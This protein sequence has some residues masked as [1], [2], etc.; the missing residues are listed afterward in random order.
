MAKVEIDSII[1]EDHNVGE[2]YC[3]W[4]QFKIS[5]EEILNGVRFAL[6]DCPHALVWT[7]TYHQDR[8]MLIIH[9]TID[10]REE[11]EEFIESIQEFVSD[12]KIGLGDALP[13][14]L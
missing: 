12:W 14:S 3:L 1:S 7:I 8:S 4:G 10:D 11:G 6:L 9:C 5:R 2:I 13:E